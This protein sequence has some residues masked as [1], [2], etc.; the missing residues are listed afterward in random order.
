VFTCYRISLTAYC[1]ESIKEERLRKMEAQFAKK[2]VAEIKKIRRDHVSL[3]LD[4]S[5]FDQLARQIPKKI[6]RCH[7]PGRWYIEYTLI[8]CVK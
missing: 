5:Y 6:E 3:T 7:V 4:K 8:F 2:K 1:D